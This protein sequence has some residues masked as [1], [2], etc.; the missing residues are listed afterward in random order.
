MCQFTLDVIIK[1]SQTLTVLL[2]LKRR[3]HPFTLVVQGLGV[4]TEFLGQKIKQ[5]KLIIY[6]KIFE[7]NQVFIHSL[8]LQKC[9]NIP[10]I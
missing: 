8:F 5:E 7:L 4:L 10:N 1:L 2:P 3:F 6:I 9:P